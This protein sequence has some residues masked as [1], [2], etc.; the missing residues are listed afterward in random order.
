M[1]PISLYRATPKPRSF[2]QQERAAPSYPNSDRHV[3]E[4][5]P[6]P[7]Q[8][9]VQ[10]ATD[11]SQSRKVNKRFVLN[12]FSLLFYFLL[13][14]TH[15]RKIAQIIRVE[16]D[17]FS[18]TEQPIEAMTRSG[19]RTLPTQWCVCFSHS[20]SDYF[21]LPRRGWTLER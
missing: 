20:R 17:D 1:E 10:R 18:K 14:K 16:L 11:V 2:I 15:V 12:C 4:S 21:T 7:E 8:G 5:R 3:N 19:N 13:N 6:C 9:E